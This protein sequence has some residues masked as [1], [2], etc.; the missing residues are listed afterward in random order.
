MGICQAL[1]SAAG[2]RHARDIR[3]AESVVLGTYATA[4][5][6][7][8]SSHRRYHPDRH[9]GGA[10]TVDA[11]ETNVIILLPLLRCLSA[12]TRLAV[13]LALTTVGLFLII[14]A[15]AHGVIAVIVGAI[16]LVSV[17]RNRQRDRLGYP[18]R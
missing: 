12:R 3:H 6:M 10:E 5:E 16:F 17:G 7:S 2:R 8:V 13:G 18:T 4:G 11:K 9:R 14:A 1:A 15:L